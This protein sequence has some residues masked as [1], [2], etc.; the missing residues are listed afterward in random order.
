MA[1]AQRL[2]IARALSVKPE[3]LVCDESAEALDVSIQAQVLNLFIE[4]REDLNLTYLFIRH[5]LGVVEHISDRFVI[6][7]LRRIVEIARSKA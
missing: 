1:N 5:D 6:M 4:L 7:Y 3:F 2:S